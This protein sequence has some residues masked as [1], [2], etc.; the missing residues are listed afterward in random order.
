MLSNLSNYTSASTPLVV[1]IN[2]NPFTDHFTVSIESEVTEAGI[3]KVYDN[4]G[5]SIN[6]YTIFLTPGWNELDIRMEQ[7]PAGTYFLK[8]HTAD[9]DLLVV[10]RLEK[11]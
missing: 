11:K 2:P 3:I 8:C 6:T 10:V 4:A 7:V 9:S 1:T 5:N